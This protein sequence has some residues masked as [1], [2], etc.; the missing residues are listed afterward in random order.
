LYE[1]LADEVVIQQPDDVKEI[2]FATCMLDAY[3][4]DLCNAVLD[5]GDSDARLRDLD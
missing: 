3:G 5:T 2:L 1:Y 4:E